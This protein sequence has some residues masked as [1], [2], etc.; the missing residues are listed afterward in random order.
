MRI[1]R[2]IER[3]P[4]QH[5][6]EWLLIV[7][8]FCEAFS[9]CSSDD[10]STT[11]LPDG[12]YPLQ[13]T[14]EVSQ[15]Q[16]RAAGKDTWTGGE[17]IIVEMKGEFGSKT[18]VMDAAGNA[19]PKDADNAFYWKN[20]DEDRISAWTPD[21]EVETDI[22]DQTKGYAAFDVLYASTIGRYDQAINLRFVHRMA[23][24]E[25]TLKTG[26]GITEEELKG[27]TVTI[28]G[29]PLTHST[30]GLVAPG[31][32]SDGE[33]K[34]YYDAAT[35]KYESLVP[36]QDMTGKPLIRINIG[37]NAFTYTP[38]TEAA[39]KFDYFGGK[40]YAYTITVKADGI[41]V[42]TVTGATWGYDGEED[43]ASARLFK[44]D[45]LK[46]GD[47]FY[48]DGT[49]SDGGLRKQYADGSVVTA[50]PK[51]DPMEGKTV[52]GIVFQT[53]PSR[54]GA[55]E[56]AKLGAG[57]VHGLVMCV[58][59]AATGQ[60]WNPENKDAGLTKCTTKAENYN[61]ISGYGNGEHIRSSRGNFDN[62]PAFKAA[63]DYS[64]TCPVPATTTGWFLPSSGQWWDILQNLG[65]CTALA[66]A[67]QQTSSDS[68]YLYWKGQ[69][70]VPAALNAWMEKIA[71]D[72]K[73]NFYSNEWFWSSSE[74]SENQ[75]RT[76]C[77]G[78]S[79]F[80]VSVQNAKDRFLL[81]RPVLAF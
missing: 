1:I 65:G 24:I 43:V 33:I 57:K 79:G 7:V 59:N 18:Y 51:P 25:V 81:V 55:T 36:P 70:D 23:K 14:A 72:N 44:A 35:K 32:Q 76:W 13:L 29:D 50:D 5:I 61:D 69:G 64:S 46:V 27:A 42:R 8:L 74:D 20:T 60:R 34:P 6:S 9:S 66:D 75:A 21:L 19:V 41:D 73:S 12:K 3:R 17:E 31:N 38:D 22:S 16:T 49:W 56:K 47:Y 37:S 54:I 30:A 77:F 53:D 15:P 62:Y 40:R 39:G 71:A 68:N 4:W 26:E 11:P 2:N 10:E 80:V 78:S 67:T 28:F 45:E 48:S 58:K 52:V 63:D